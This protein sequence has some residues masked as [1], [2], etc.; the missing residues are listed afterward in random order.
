MS[1]FLLRFKANYL[2]K[3]RGYPYFSLWMPIA[4]A[5][6]YFFP[7]GPNLAQKPLYLV[8]TVLN[9]FLR[10]VSHSFQQFGKALQKFSLKIIIINLE[11]FSIEC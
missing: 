9:G 5:K 11:Q 1:A 10:N 3:M 8:G 2:E 6:I 4:V 7:H